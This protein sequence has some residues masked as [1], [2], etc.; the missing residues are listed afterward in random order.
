MPKVFES[1][2]EFKEALARSLR[3][4]G[5]RV[6]KV[7][8]HGTV[9]VPDLYVMPLEF[10]MCGAFW[11]ELKRCRGKKLRD[12]EPGGVKAGMRAGQLAWHGDY[13]SSWRGERAVAVAAC[14]D[15]GFCLASSLPDFEGTF[16]S[17]SC[18]RLKG[19]PDLGTLALAVKLCPA[20]VDTATYGE[21][22]LKVLLRTLNWSEAFSEKAGHCLHTEDDAG[23]AWLLAMRL[24][25]LGQVPDDPGS[26]TPNKKK[27]MWRLQLAA[28]MHRARKHGL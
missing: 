12:V 17:S 23:Q 21:S 4:E 11:V 18:V 9:G 5:A 3:K 7:E 28:S 2:A 19:L 26:W 16:G 13:F 24:G 10:G 20:A 25:L 22:V 27:D 14:L 1:E 8:S 15:D 6:E